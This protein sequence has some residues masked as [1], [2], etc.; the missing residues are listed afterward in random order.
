VILTISGEQDPNAEPG[1]GQHAG[2]KLPAVIA[3]RCIG[4]GICEYNCPVNNGAAIR[5][6]SLSQTGF[7]S[8]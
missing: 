6:R 2:V 3:N 8:R 1:S 5:V 4:C 7:L